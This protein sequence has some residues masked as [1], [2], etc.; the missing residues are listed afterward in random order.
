[1]AANW[2]KK[3]QLKTQLHHSGVY[4]TRWFRIWE[5]KDWTNP[6][7]VDRSD[8]FWKTCFLD[9]LLVLS[10]KPDSEHRKRS[11]CYLR[12]C[13]WPQQRP[14]KVKM[15]YSKSM[16]QVMTSLLEGNLISSWEDVYGPEKDL[17]PPHENNGDR[18][19]LRFSMPSS[20]YLQNLFCS[21]HHHI[22]GY[23]QQSEDSQGNQYWQKN[24][25]GEDLSWTFPLGRSLLP[26]ESPIE[27]FARMNEL[28]NQY[29][30]G[31]LYL[32]FLPEN[33]FIRVDKYFEN[34]ELDL[35]KSILL[36]IS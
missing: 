4:K 13:L 32:K 34:K 18:H 33:S 36:R 25:D 21:H 3:V 5:G 35:I 17:G 26:L 9:G 28:M 12:Q 23:F 27:P 10:E 15:V 8:T 24:L 11:F 7:C 29:Q 19:R 16:N 2:Y 20:K 6:W 22:S 31:F 1:M 14:H 30:V